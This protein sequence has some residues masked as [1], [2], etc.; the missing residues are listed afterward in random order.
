MSYTVSPSTA[1]DICSASE[2]VAA[3]GSG[4]LRPSH[5]RRWTSKRPPRSCVPRRAPTHPCRAVTRDGTSVVF[6]DLSVPGQITETPAPSLPLAPGEQIDWMTFSRDGHLLLVNFHDPSKETVKDP[7]HPTGSAV[8]RL[9]AAGTPPR[10]EEEALGS[11][12][13]GMRLALRVINDAH[14]MDSTDVIMRSATDYHDIWRTG[15][16]DLGEDA[17]PDRAES[18]CARYR[19]APPGRD[20]RQWQGGD[21][22]S[23]RHA[24]CLHPRHRCTGEGR[25]FRCCVQ[26]GR[27][28]A[29]VRRRR[30]SACGSTN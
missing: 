18:L 9:G 11:S 16:I 19:R 17:V 12:G 2:K 6:R 27:Y 20:E 26:P 22:E 15:T 29:R 3:A 5:T 23:E 7:H 25:T 21:L 10:F 14:P 30:T 4:T 24:P 1:T 28:A 13:D 8:V